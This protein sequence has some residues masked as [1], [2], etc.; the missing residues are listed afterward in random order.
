MKCGD[1]SDGN[2]ENLP[3]WCPGRSRQYWTQK[4]MYLPD[5]CFNVK[6]RKYLY[7][8]QKKFSWYMNFKGPKWTRNTRFEFSSLPT[9]CVFFRCLNQHFGP[10]FFNIDFAMYS[11]QPVKIF[12]KNVNFKGLNGLFEPKKFEFSS[13]PTV[14][15][16]L[17]TLNQHFD[18]FFKT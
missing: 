16:F 4:S 11:V 6:I 7:V 14:L 15:A 8:Y 18:L 3:F 9:V 12:L 2:R 13:P 10:I 17:Q 1:G 5:F